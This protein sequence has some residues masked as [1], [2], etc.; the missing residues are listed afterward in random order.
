MDQFLRYQIFECLL[1]KDSKKVS[2]QGGN[3]FLPEQSIFILLQ[4]VAGAYLG[5][6]CTT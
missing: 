5:T 3:F 1:K 2:N 4:K 6:V